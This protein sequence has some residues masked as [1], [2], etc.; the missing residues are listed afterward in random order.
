MGIS[1]FSFVTDDFGE[2]IERWLLSS[3]DGSDD[4]NIKELARLSG[5]N[6][7][8]KLNLRKT[9]DNKI[10]IFKSKKYADL[11]KYYNSPD[12]YFYDLFYL[13]NDLRYEIINKPTTMVYKYPDDTKKH[14]MSTTHFVFNMI[15]W[16]PLFILG[17][18]VNQSNTY[19]PKVFNN[20]TYVEFMNTKVIEPYKHLTTHNQMSRILAKMYDMFI[21]ITERYG[22]DLGLTFSMHDLITKWDNPEI[23]DINH[24]CIDKNMQLS[25]SEKYLNA[26]LKRYS[27]IMMNDPNPNILKPLLRSGQGANTKQLREF[28]INIGF[29]PDLNG[30]TYEIKTDTNFMNRGLRD[31]SSYVLDATGGRK[32]AVLALGIDDSG[33]LQRKYCKL[34]QNIY[35]DPDPEYDCDSVNYYE[36]TIS[37]YDDLNTMHGRWYVSEENTL[38]QLINTDNILLGKTLKFRSPAQCAC[39]KDGRGICSTCYGHLYSQNININ[40]GINSAIIA[41]ERTYQNSMSAKHVLFTDTATA[42]FSEFFCDYFDLIEGHRVQ[43]NGD[44][45]DIENYEIVININD[46]TK[47]RD[48]DD[49][50]DNEYIHN[51]YIHDKE[52]NEMIGINEVNN[53]PVIITGD[54]F[55]Q[56]VEYRKYKKYDDEGWIII[57]LNEEYFDQDMFIVLLDNR[58]ITKPLNELK[59]LIEQGREIDGVASPSELIDKLNKLMRDADINIESVHIEVIARNLIRDPESI[60]DL[61]DYKVENPNRIIVSIQRAL[62]NDNSVITSITYERLKDQFSDPSTFIKTGVGEMARLFVSE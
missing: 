44:I 1:K 19:M 47:D 27:E 45:E 36:K 12:D 21:F 51:F 5:K 10:V 43:L 22:R 28:A 48:I 11:W 42:Q 7:I 32:A 2:E 18:P 49:L 60:I 53:N 52:N 57:P 58:E 25:D 56:I 6:I 41:S 16:M 59:K 14:T 9:D 13:M 3:K 26:R 4:I 39:H 40:I 61:P 30:R 17:I 35:L 8:K 15:I 23:Y 38:R 31:I 50:M 34:A 33:Y 62:M 55:N 29:K 37:S 54:L 46:I 24:T 20:K